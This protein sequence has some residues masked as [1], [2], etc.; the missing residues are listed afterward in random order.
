MWCGLVH[1]GGQ[2]RGS[3]TKFPTRGRKRGKNFRCGLCAKKKMPQALWVRGGRLGWG[4]WFTAVLGHPRG[5]TLPAAQQH[6]A[7]QR[8]AELASDLRGG[9]GCCGV[10]G[11]D[12]TIIRGTPPHPRPWSRPPFRGNAAVGQ[13]E[14]NRPRLLVPPPRPSPLC[15]MA[16]FL[17][18]PAIF[19]FYRCLFFGTFC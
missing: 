15:C 14:K 6:S 16:I 18:T 5:G 8:H 10:A 13:R 12:G 11:A 7:S 17:K 3:S 9:G 4:D 19:E 2:K 1:R